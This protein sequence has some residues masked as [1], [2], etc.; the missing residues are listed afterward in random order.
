MANALALV[1]GVS[2]G[3][4][5]ERAT[6]LASRGCDLIIAAEDERL[7]TAGERLRGFDALVTEVRADLA[8]HSGVNELWQAVEADGRLLDIACINAGVG[9]GGLFWGTDLDT[10]L[11]MIELNCVG[12]IQLAKYFVRHMHAN[13][14]GRIL[15]TSSIAGEMVGPRE[16]VYATTQAF[17]L[18]FAH[19]LRYELRASGV[20]VTALQPGQTDT[21]FFH[22]AGMDDTEV[23]QT[24]KHDSSPRDVARQG[25]EAL[26]AGKDHV[27]AASMKTKIEGMVANVIPGVAKGAIHDKQ[28]RPKTEKKAS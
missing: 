2:S 28:A 8:T 16:A 21:D 11:K 15:L 19:T 14:R 25:I 10:E 23:G 20:T 17:G 22:R 3:I 5:Y 24:G 18:S 4:G 6:E 27:Y 13:G 12:T 7:E 1:T 26:L 9:L